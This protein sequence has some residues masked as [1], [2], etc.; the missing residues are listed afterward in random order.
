MKYKHIAYIVSDHEKSSLLLQEIKSKINIK[1]IKECKDIDLIIV[2]GGDGTLLHSIHNYMY[3][4]VPFYGINTGTI[5]FLMNSISEDIEGK[6][7]NSKTTILH[8][9]NMIAVNENGEISQSL[10]INEVS[11][12]RNINHVAKFKI[13]V[14][15]VEQIELS[16]DG[17]LVSTPAGSSAY[18][19]SAGG[20]IVPLQSNILC[21]T[22]IC[23]FRPRR[24]NGALLPSKSIIEFILDKDSIGKVNAVADFNEVKN[25]CSVRIHEDKSKEILLL[26]NNDSSL[27]QRFLKEQFLY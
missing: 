4:N 13:L 9:L 18:N 27:E 23:P 10:A 14:D 21:I 19:F 26:F 20:R 7:D 12:Y 22:P 3:L 15:G 2:I 8:P 24:W 25:V 16:A 1:D 5:G 6:I 17:A 11:I